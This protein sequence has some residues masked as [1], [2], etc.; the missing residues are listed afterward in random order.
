MTLKQTFVDEKKTITDLIDKFRE[1]NLMDSEKEGLKAFDANWATYQTLLDDAITKVDAGK[2]KEVI[3]SLGSVSMA[4]S[5]KALGDALN[6]LQEINREDAER[7]KSESESTFTASTLMIILT[8]IIGV[9]AALSLGYII[10]RSI[11]VPLGKVVK[12]LNELSKGHLQTRLSLDRK[13]EVGVMAATMDTYADYQQNAIVGTLHKNG[14][15]REA[16]NSA[17]AS[18]ES[19]AALNQVAQIISDL[20]V[21]ATRINDSMT[22]LNG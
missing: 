10:S 3:D 19:S 18:E 22:R 16:T 6:Q 17:A 21:I 12:M 5:R 1:S 15:A 7:I 8:G 4:E 9:I 20:S 13:D 14:N 2:D 11:S